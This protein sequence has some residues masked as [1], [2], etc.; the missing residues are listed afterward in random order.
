MEEQ[1][2]EMEAKDEEIRRLTAELLKARGSDTQLMYLSVPV[3]ASS[4]SVSCVCSSLS[5]VMYSLH[6]SLVLRSA[7]DLPLRQGPADET[8][9]T[10]ANNSL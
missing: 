6:S 4:L 1:D 8:D 2:K 10:E 3:A 5:T 9:L 7:A